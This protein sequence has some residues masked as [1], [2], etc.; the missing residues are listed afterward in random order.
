MISECLKKKLV[1]F[2]TICSLL[3]ISCGKKDKL[4]TYLTSLPDSLEVSFYLQDQKGRPLASQNKNR[5]IPSASI[6][7]IPILVVLLQLEEKGKLD[8]GEKLELREGDKVG[9]AGELQHQPAGIF[10]TLDQL[11]EEMIRISDNVAT[12]LLIRVVGMETVQHWLSDNGF[13]ATQLNRLMMDFDAIA[14]GRQNYTS[15]EEI[16]NMLASLYAGAYLGEKATAK[17]MGLLLK[18]ADASMIPAK[19]PE[20]VRVAHKTGVL[21]YVRGDAGII[22]GD[23]PLVLSVFVEGFESSEQAQEVIATI[24]RMAYDGF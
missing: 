15:P 2:A 20:G 24:A 12:N 16:S 14:E 10:Y 17:L 22:L 23:S 9:G 6:I 7:K 1:L 4:E 13:Q 18:C 8:M 19:L 11:A 3:L 5:Q 21:D